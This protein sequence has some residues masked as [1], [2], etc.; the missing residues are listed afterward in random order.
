MMTALERQRKA[1][2]RELADLQEELDLAIAEQNE[3][4]RKAVEELW[5]QADESRRR[6]AEDRRSM[7]ADYRSLMHLVAERDAIEDAE[8]ARE[9]DVTGP[10][11]TLSQGRWL[12][13]LQTIQS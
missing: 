7:Q 13:G 5:R 12:R 2:E 11:S 10:A 9:Q 8:D 1:F 4:H 3:E 6:A